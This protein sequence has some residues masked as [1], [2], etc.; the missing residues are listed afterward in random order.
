[1]LHFTTHAHDVSAFSSP[2]FSTPGNLVPAISTH[3][4]WSRVFQSRLFHP[5]ELV[6]RFPVPRFQ[7]PH[8]SVDIGARA[9]L[10]LVDKFCYSGDM[11]IA[12]GDADAAVEA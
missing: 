2:T 6:P 3:A 7:S 12:D 5:C 8:T 11:L 4:L 1:M 10:E 9:K